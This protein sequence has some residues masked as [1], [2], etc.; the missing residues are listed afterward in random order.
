MALVSGGSNGAPGERPGTDRPRLAHRA[1][2][3]LGQALAAEDAETVGPR[4]DELL[5]DPERAVSLLGAPDAWAVARHAV[6]Q[7]YGRVGALLVVGFEER[8]R[9]RAGGEA[10]AVP[11]LEELLDGFPSADAAGLDGILAALDGEHPDDV[12]EENTARRWLHATYAVAERDGT[13]EAHRAYMDALDRLLRLAG[14][15]LAS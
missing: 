10:V 3:L 1:S 14:R 13:D 12:D 2:G 5:A 15:R 6:V 9:A 4:A 8:H 7:R 11:E